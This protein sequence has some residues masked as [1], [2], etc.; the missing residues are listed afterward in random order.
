MHVDIITS[1]YKDQVY[2]GALLRETY[3]D[4]GKVRHRTLANLSALPMHIVQM[5]KRSLKG[6]AFVSA[7]EALRV[8]RSR[9]HGAVWSVWQVMRSLGVPELLGGRK[10]PWQDRALGMILSRVIRAASKRFTAA[11]WE[12]TSLPEWLEGAADVS[13]QTLY[14]A[15]DALL[16][17]QPAIEKMLAQ[18]HLRKGSLVL[19]DV[20]SS[21]VEGRR[22]PLA[23]F[24][25]NRDRKRGTKQIVLGLLTNHQG[26]PVAVEVFSGRTSDSKTL[27]AQLEKL[28]M[29]F[30]IE[31]VLLAGDCGMITKLHRQALNEHGYA[32][33]TALK[34]P[35]V[36]NLRQR[37][38]LQLSLFDEH[39]LAEIIDPENPSR[40]LVL[41]RNFKVGV[42]RRRKREDLLQATEMELAK[43][44]TSV[45][46]GRLKDETK[47]ALKVGKVIGKF[48]VGKHFVLTIEPGRFEFRR[49]EAAIAAEAA[50]DGIYVVETNVGADRL[51]AE[52]AV[53]SY[54]SL[55][56]VERA[57]RAMKT[58]HLELRPI[59]HRLA[60]RVRAHA[61]LCM[62][63]YYVQWHMEQALAP[64]RERQPD[65]YQSF[66]HVL[67]RLSE[68]QLNTVRVRDQ[69]VTFDQVTEPDEHQRLFLDHL[70]VR[71]LAP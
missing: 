27:P 54:K 17:R 31:E 23:Q 59:F 51:A 47:I 43:I 35:E 67:D 21:Y 70:G 8:V 10:E 1:R 3:R 57:F 66:R 60:D 30:G 36:R 40:R 14:K 65:A 33:I 15:M 53:S 11:W 19:Y 44:R 63:A 64:L 7:N 4:N 39:D 5:I 9:S 22:C 26:C 45:A 24:G 28:K 25:Y 68:L 6:E 18:R 32:W 58:M 12:G 42:E 55:R 41:C 20:T 13:V 69:D 71:S 61:L 38:L 62:L 34:A 49:D 37:G 46:E 16:R 50:L 29:R 48:K 52:E 56:H 2:S